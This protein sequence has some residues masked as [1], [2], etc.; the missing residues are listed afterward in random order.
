MTRNRRTETTVQVLILLLV[1]AMAGAASFTHVHDWTMRNAPAATASWFGWANA[2]ISELTPAAAGIEIRRRKRRGQPVR[3]PMTVLIAAAVLSLAAQV[4]QARPTPAG[5]LSA[6]VPA[7]AFLALTK[8]LLSRPAVT[9]GEPPCPTPLPAPPGQIL[10]TTTGTSPTATSV[11]SAAGPTPIPTAAPAAPTPTP[12]RLR[13]LRPV[14]SGQLQISA[15]MTAFA[16]QQETG[17]PITPGQLA[18]RLTVPLALAES[19]ID[20]LDGTTPPPVTAVNGT[21]VTREG[22]P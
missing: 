2:I 5:W 12:D 17:Q 20:H 9:S 3:Y 11:P 1:A 10:T 18:D 22:P 13:E 7:L 6:A 19:L 4:A 8:L 16:H 21:P 15:R 14:P